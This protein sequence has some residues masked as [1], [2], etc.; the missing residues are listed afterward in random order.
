MHP[1]LQA[2]WRRVLAVRSGAVAVVDAATGR[3][4][5]FGEIDARADAW[6]AQHPPTQG[7]VG[8]VWCLALADRAAWLAV[9]LAAIKTG[10]V[11]LPVE[12]DA[13][14]LLRQRAL[15]AGA[16]LL[17]AEVGVEALAGGARH[18]NCLLIKLTSGTTGEP[19]PLPFTAAEMLADGGQ[20]MRSM[21]ITPADR[22]FAV[23]PLGHSYGLGNLVL[24][25]FMAGVP[26]V[27]GSAPYP[28][29]MA[30]ELT[31]FPCTVLPLVPPLVKALAAVATDSAGLQQLRLVLS[32]GSALKPDIARRFHAQTGQRVHNFYGSSETGGICF[33]RSGEAAQTDGAVGTPLDGVAL[34]LTQAGAIHIRSEAICH[35]RYPAGAATLHDFGY[36][37][38]EVVLRL[39]GRHADIV[40][41][42]G[43][44]LSLA[45]IEAA[46]C[47]LEGV[48]DAYVTVREGRSGE[49]RC[50]ALYAGGIDS[51]MVVRSLATSLP[52]WKQPKILRKVHTIAYTARGKKDRRAMERA[53]DALTA[54]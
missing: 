7:G 23:I 49:S 45:E 19:Q 9:F 41:I 30:D 36:L 28:Q 40:K 53:V 31:R 2:C 3:S 48:E 24:P 1:E 52:A 37:D 21:S 16:S 22:N 12:S 27:L 35:A 43:R 26:I 50:V 39:T 14:H 15:G 5:T 11:V 13:P 34:S 29:V 54:R 51:E 6:L 42:A 38:G 47:N 17:V 10:A 20:I 44:R 4:W 46:L 33:D 8:Q 32:A 25:F 18:E